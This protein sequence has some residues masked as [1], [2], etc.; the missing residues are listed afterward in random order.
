MIFEHVLEENI[1]RLGCV[2]QIVSLK[3]GIEHVQWF[4]LIVD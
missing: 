2:R 3:Q 1:T 4:H